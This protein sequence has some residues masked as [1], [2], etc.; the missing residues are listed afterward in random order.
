MQTT[1]GAPITT[2]FILCDNLV[3]VHKV[4]GLEVVALQGLDLSVARGEVVGIVGSSGSGKSTLLSILGGLDHPTA[5]RAQVDGRDLL[6]MSDADMT[7]YRREKVGFVWQQGG[8]NLVPYL[9]AQQN[10]ELPMLLAGRAPR[11]ARARAQ[12]LLERVGLA[13]RRRHRMSALSGGEQQRVAIAI[14]LA[15]APPLLLADEP[16]GELDSVTAEAIFRTFR[17][18]RDELGVTVVIVSH[19]RELARQVDRVLGIQDGKVAT[20]TTAAASHEVRAMLDSAGRL[21]IPKALRER[22]GVGTRVILEP[23]DDGLIIRPVDPAQ[24]GEKH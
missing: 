4:A 8:R 3:K 12:M 21:Q 16:T 22:Y 7:R 11:L 19:D 15:N 13:D 9:D 6:K 10:V 20:E 18:V 5:G 24:N 23:T 1:P 14:A 2:P 17:E